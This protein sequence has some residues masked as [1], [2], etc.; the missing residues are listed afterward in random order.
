MA[1]AA[2]VG[3]LRWVAPSSV[4]F[5]SLPGT[6]P[7]A[8]TRERGVRRYVPVPDAI[9]TGPVEWPDGYLRKGGGFKDSEGVLAFYQ[10]EVTYYADSGY[11]KVIGY[12]DLTAFAARPCRF[13]PSSLDLRTVDET[14]TFKVGKELIANAEFI[15]EAKGVASAVYSAHSSA[16]ALYRLTISSFGSSS[17]AKVAKI[18]NQFYPERFP[19]KA[20]LREPP[21]VVEA[22]GFASA[23]G[24]RSALVRAKVQVQ[25]TEVD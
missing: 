13:S 11:V 5:P 20:P 17:P 10:D 15:L 12:A 8:E 1:R 22:P 18:L 14:M 16:G 19:R 25:L 6:P 24:L 21:I 2:E 9:C 4:P 23:E 7:V 3:T